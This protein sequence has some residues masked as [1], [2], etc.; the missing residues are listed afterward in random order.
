[1]NNEEFFNEINDDITVVE[2]NKK[3]LIVFTNSKDTS[4]FLELLELNKQV[5]NRTLITLNSGSNS[6]KFLNR[7]QNYDGKM[8]LCLTGDRTGNAIT[9]KILTEFNGKNIKDVRPL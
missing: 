4:S 3:E 2:G 8:F 6:K 1:M 9:R 7:Y 5:N